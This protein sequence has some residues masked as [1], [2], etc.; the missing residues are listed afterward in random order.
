MSQVNKSGCTLAHIAAFNNQPQVLDILK[1]YGLD[2][3]Q[4]TH[5][6]ITPADIAQSKNYGLFLV[7]LRKLGIDLDKVSDTENPHHLT[8]SPTRLEELRAAQNTDPNTLNDQSIA[9]SGSFYS[10]ITLNEESPAEMPV[11]VELSEA[12]IDPTTSPSDLIV[13]STPLDLNNTLTDNLSLPNVAKTERAL[14]A[15]TATRSRNAPISKRRFIISAIIGAILI[16]GLGVAFTLTGIFAPLGVGLLGLGLT[17]M[18]SGITG[19]ALG[20][21]FNHLSQKSQ[22]HLCSNNLEHGA[23]TIEQRPEQS[24]NSPKGPNCPSYTTAFR[25]LKN[26]TPPP[27]IPHETSLVREESRQNETRILV[28]D[29][30]VVAVATPTS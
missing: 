23:S 11:T 4:G 15:E 10:K 16:I 12:T 13:E 29:S 19:A 30:L 17:T 1:E 24:R 27:G 14:I 9:S 18:V 26:N 7:Q 22:R 2:L 5:D 25:I 3:N 28:A 21:T 8:E 20:L 6:G